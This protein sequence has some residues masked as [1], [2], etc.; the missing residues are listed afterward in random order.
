M[1]ALIL[2]R[3]KPVEGLVIPTSSKK[4]IRRYG[5]TVAML[6][7]LLPLAAGW[8]MFR[9]QAQRISVLAVSVI[10]GSVVCLIAS[11]FIFLNIL[12][13]R[14]VIGADRLQVVRGKGSVV[15][16]IPYKNMVQVTPHENFLGFCVVGID[17]ADRRD[18]DTFWG[19]VHRGNQHHPFDMII[20]DF[21][22]DSTESI[23]EKVVA[24]QSRWKEQGE[25]PSCS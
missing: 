3:P 25:V 14:L 17:V 23:A 7:G 24:A 15:A 12:R 16:Q 10:I 6:L 11:P 21:Y 13:S 18:R 1:V 9:F 2:R 5:I 4:G 22:I 19:L 8:F 20:N